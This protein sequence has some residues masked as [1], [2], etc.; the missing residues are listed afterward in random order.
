MQISPLRQVNAPSSQLLKYLRAQNRAFTSITR[1]CTA[2]T[3][4]RP[5]YS[6]HQDNHAHVSRVTGIARASRHRANSTATHTSCLAKNSPRRDA[7]SGHITPTSQPLIPSESFLT[8][9]DRFWPCK[10]S[11]HDNGEYTRTDYDPIP[12]HASRYTATPSHLDRSFSILRPH[13]QY[14]QTLNSA[15][16]LS[17]S[18]QPHAERRFFRHLWPS[19]ESRHKSSLQPNDLPPLSNGPDDGANLGRLLRPANELMLR[20]TEFDENGNVTVNGDFK[21]SELIAKVQLPLFVPPSP[22]QVYLLK[23]LTQPLLQ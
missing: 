9:F 11:T 7:T 12:S 22:P 17:T 21:K 6:R 15:R 14:E 8:F 16:L 18:T 3:Q 20:C 19:K 13:R 5:R 1:P 10:K 2:I 4:S 23:L